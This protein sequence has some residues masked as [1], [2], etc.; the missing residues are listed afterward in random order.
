MKTLENLKKTQE[1]YTE[2]LTKLH[3]LF[4]QEI[5][6]V[7]KNTKD[8]GVLTTISNLINQASQRHLGVSATIFQKEQ[9]K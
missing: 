5:K 1:Q 9:E 2:Q 3:D 6:K 8:L 7:E 4:L